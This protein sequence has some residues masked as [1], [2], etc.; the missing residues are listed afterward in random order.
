MTVHVVQWLL[1]ALHAALAIGTGGHALL[2]RRDPRG[3]WGWIAVVLLFPF[4][5]PLLYYWFGINR[6][7][8]RAQ[9][10]VG[11]EEK[12]GIVTGTPPTS[13][14]R[15]AGVAEAEMLELVRIGEAMSGR[16]LCSGNLVE[17]LV[18]GEQA[19]PAM[20]DAIARAEHT[21]CLASYIFDGGAAG[22]QFVAALV[23]AQ[24]RGVDVRVLVD[25]VADAWYRPSAAKMLQGLGVPV[26]RFLP[27]RL[28]PPMLHVN[29]RNHR[30]LLSIDGSVAFT[31]GMNISD[32]HYVDERGSGGT[33]DLHFRVTGPVVQ[34]L[35]R[36]FADDWRFASGKG[37]KP[38]SG[39]PRHAGTAACRVITDGPNLDMAALVMVLLGALATAHKRVLIMTPYFLPPLE[40]I[41]ALQSA[42]L[43]GVEV[44]IVLPERSNQRPVDFATRNL[45]WQLLQRQVRVYYAPPPFAH[46]KLF[47]IDD[48]YAQIGSANVDERSLRLNFELVLEVFDQPFVAKLASHFEAARAKSR[49]VTLA[50]LQARSLPVKVRDALCWLFSVY[51]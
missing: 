44:A 35:E 20:L 43:R 32:R 7:R 19:Y 38:R 11:S 6:I 18:N 31:G 51:L 50:E 21:I 28:M 3:A 47:V 9:R 46:T 23:A 13:L 22:R 24:S 2:T 17:P 27:P 42:A 41:G 36:A 34:Q 4:A 15:V 16:P 12:R 45:L 49:E 10:M 1:I 33:A 37:M 39:S 5:G 25:G 30:K 29:L 26:A 8:M 14:P 40:L 48:Y